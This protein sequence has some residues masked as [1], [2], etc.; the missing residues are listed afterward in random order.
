MQAGSLRFFYAPCAIAGR[1]MENWVLS[2][3]QGFAPVERRSS[4]D[5]VH[6]RRVVDGGV[7]VSRSESADCG[8]ESRHT[9]GSPSPRPRCSE[10]SIL[11]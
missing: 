10:E 1:E 4:P 8:L 3:P 2:P 6:I 11:N 7:S 5:C 9:V